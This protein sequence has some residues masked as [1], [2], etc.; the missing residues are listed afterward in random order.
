M[1][2]L[3][4]RRQARSSDLRTVVTHIDGTGLVDPER[5]T[6]RSTASRAR[7]TVRSRRWTSRTAR[8]TGANATGRRSCSHGRTARRRP[9]RARARTSRC[10]CSVLDRTAAASWTSGRHRVAP[11]RP[12]GLPGDRDLA[13]RNATCTSTYMSF[14]QP[15]HSTTASPR[16]F[17]GVVRHADVSGGAIGAWSDAPPR[18]R[19]GDAR[20]SSANALTDEFLG[21]YDYAF[22]TNDFVVAVWNDARNAADCR[23]DRR[24]PAGHR[25]RRRGRRR[26]RSD[27]SGAEQHLP[28]DVRQHG[29]L[30]RLVR[31]PDAVARDRLEGGRERPPSSIASATQV[32]ALRG[33]CVPTEPGWRAGWRQA[34]ARAG[35]R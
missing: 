1:V 6:S 19:P 17:Q 30:R 24:V 32:F 4:R 29:H 14:L 35:E 18:Y 23:A 21:D 9:T 20:G 13:R 33:I 5:A 8:P 16:M 11:D 15:W 7:A 12:A 2:A 28:A 22:A 34:R 10:A 25:R 26:C 31:R 3:V 27:P